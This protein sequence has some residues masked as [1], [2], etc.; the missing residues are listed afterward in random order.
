MNTIIAE[1]E[2]SVNTEASTILGVRIHHVTMRQALKTME[3]LAERTQPTL[4][5]TVNPEFIMLS[6]KN[7]AFRQVLN[8]STLAVPDGIGVVLAS[9][10][11]RK[12][13]KE[14][15][16]GVDLVEGFAEVAARKR[17]RIFFLGAR[18]G[19]AEEAARRLHDRH[20]G[21]I[22]AGTFSGSADP[23]EEESICRRIKD[24]APHLLLVAYG[25]PKQE[26]WIGRNLER[27]NVPLTI[28]VGG[29]FDFISG[30]SIRAPQW[31]RSIGLEWLHRL[32]REPYRWRRMLALPR[33]AWLIVRQTSL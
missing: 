18:P 17:L 3:T 30:A 26:L 21:F 32:I 31:I 10:W 15:V 1:K 4:I 9:R 6:Q 27:L 33:F 24:A 5:V 13:L 8:A 16:T 14:R 2:S 22:I 7:E 19:I 11:L 20:P 25:S 23:A 12:P 28:G 29:T